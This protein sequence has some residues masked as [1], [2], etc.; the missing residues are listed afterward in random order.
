MPIHNRKSIEV[1]PLPQGESSSL[2]TPCFH[3]RTEAEKNSEGNPAPAA[4]SRAP[5][6]ET[7]TLHSTESQLACPTNAAQQQFQARGSV[8]LQAAQLNQPVLPCTINAGQDFH[9]ATILQ[10]AM[11]LNAINLS[12]PVGYGVN[13]APY[14]G[15][16][17]STSSAYDPATSEVYQQRQQV[18]NPVLPTMLP[19]T[20]G[21]ANGVNSG[22]YGI[23]DQPPQLFSATLSRGVADDATHYNYADIE[24]MQHTN[25]FNSSPDGLLRIQM[26][27]WIKQALAAT[28]EEDSRDAIISSAYMKASLK[29][30][31]S[32]SNQID[33]LNLDYASDWSKYV[34]VHLN[35]NNCL[36]QSNV[37]N[38]GTFEDQLPNVL[39]V[40]LA[41]ICCP[42]S[43]TLT[44]SNSAH[45]DLQSIIFYLG[46]VFYELFTGKLPLS[47]LADLADCEG[48]FVSL[49]SAATL[50]Q[51]NTEDQITARD[52]KRH[53]SGIGSS[54]N[55]C[56]LACD[57]LELLR[58]PTALCNLL[59]NMLCCVYGD[60]GEDERYTNISDLTS[61]L[62][63]MLD[64]PSTCLRSLDTNKL[65]AGLPLSEM[66]IP[67][68]EE[69]KT[70]ISCYHR[71][72]SGS[73]EIAI[74]KGES[75]SGKSYMCQKLGSSIIS[76][77]GLFL[78]G[79]FDCLFL[80]SLQHSRCIATYFL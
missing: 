76:Q 66:N 29:I 45:G 21:I 11:N 24:G 8:H 41:E 46:L 68:E 47:D 71:C 2:H 53:L 58:L 36:P 35:R 27:K 33:R 38:T 10:N 70:I 43:P 42:K 80:R 54:A 61:D 59:F 31:I 44:S 22:V 13:Y 20:E 14:C 60:L 26:N 34:V 64:K 67:R 18:F 48:A 49:S 25:E 72:M 28:G 63:F 23:V 7:S 16:I 3:S 39:D 40:A 32:L 73:N 52:P 15:A 17:N 19:G 37:V 1:R 4:A 5:T 12:F 77:G 79:K 6:M 51:D 74:I 50:A 62:Q 78:I 30:A 75:G 55:I 57:H 56:Q 69:F 9:P 65:S